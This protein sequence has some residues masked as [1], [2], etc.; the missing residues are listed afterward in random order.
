MFCTC[1]VYLCRKI[2]C[3]WNFF[4]T[5]AQLEICISYASLMLICAE[6]VYIN[7]YFCINN[8]Y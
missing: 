8:A 7:A 4:C 5:Y 6:R 1:S 2:L 3:T